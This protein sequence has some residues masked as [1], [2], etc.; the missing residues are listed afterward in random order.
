MLTEKVIMIL[1]SLKAR[2]IAALAQG[3]KHSAPESPM[4]PVVT[5]VDI[6]DTD[7]GGSVF[8]PSSKY[9]EYVRSVAYSDRSHIDM[10]YASRR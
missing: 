3:V 10:R 4:F 1:R 8:V 7:R 6:P 2:F 5:V 9:A